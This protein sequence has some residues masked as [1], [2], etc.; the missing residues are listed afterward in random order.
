MIIPSVIVA[1][2]K[3][4]QVVDRVKAGGPWRGTAKRPLAQSASLCQGA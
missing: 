3:S 2:R 1:L 4:C